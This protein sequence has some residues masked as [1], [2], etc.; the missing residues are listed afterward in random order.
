VGRRAEGLGFSEGA[1]AI[2]MGLKEDKVGFAH[3]SRGREMP[4]FL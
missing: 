3:D 4:T 1:G 2:E